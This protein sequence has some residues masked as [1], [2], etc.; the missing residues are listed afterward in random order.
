[1]HDGL[2]QFIMR[3]KT[4]VNLKSLICQRYGLTLHKNPYHTE[5]KD[6]FRICKLNF[7]RATYVTKIFQRYTFSFV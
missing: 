5:T 1:M 2:A 6:Y 4:T 3:N 7:T